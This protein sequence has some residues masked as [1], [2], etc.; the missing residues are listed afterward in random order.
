MLGILIKKLCGIA[1]S[2]MLFYQS[3]A[4]EILFDDEVNSFFTELSAP[5]L[6]TA[7]LTDREIKIQIVLSK[8]I[9]AFV[10]DGENIFIYTGLILNIDNIDALIGVI[11]HETAHIKQGH[12]LKSKREIELAQKK[13]ILSTILGIA[14]G[15][16]VNEPGVAA[17]GV[18]GGMD[19]ADLDVLKFTRYQEQAADKLALIYLNNLGIHKDGTVNFFKKLEKSERIH[20]FKSSYRLTHPLSKERIKYLEASDLT[21][22]KAAPYSYEKLVKKF[23]LMKAKIY[24]I[25]HSHS[26]TQN[27]FMGTGDSNLY[28]QSI[29]H[30]KSKNYDKALPI[31]DEL[32][33]NN[34]D[35]PYFYATKAGYLFE[36]GKIN[37]ST[38]YYEKALAI[39][40]QMPVT[41]LELANNLIM[42]KANIPRA[43]A[44]LKEVAFLYKNISLVW[45]KLGTAYHINHDYF[46]SNICYAEAN[47]LKGDKKLSM[48]FISKAKEH[49]KNVR[50]RDKIFELESKLKNLSS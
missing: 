5:I 37:E 26:E 48:N 28:A 43:I 3:N 40:S 50:Q 11:A 14:V 44:L 10:A 6:K 35:Y 46:N 27:Q 4:F 9:N 25:T 15:L 21:I 41:K 2:L 30:S 36:M 45:V 31:I 7:G 20:D 17:I 22:K 13:A 38:A 23:H 8:D 24:A 47:I 39:H 29:A 19:M 42:T 34:K 16:S 32:L 18:A 49:A 1:L 33:R 12:I